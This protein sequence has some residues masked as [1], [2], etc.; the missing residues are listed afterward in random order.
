M[1]RVRL[2]WLAALLQTAPASAD[3]PKRYA[4]LIGVNEYDHPRLPGLRFSVNDATELAAV[5]KPAGYDVTLL[6]D[7]AGQKPTKANI[8]KALKAT[9]EKCRPGDT[10]VV[11]FS[12]HGLQFKGTTDAFFCPSDARP[13]VN[14]K[15]S[16]VSLSKLYADMNDSFAGVKL[17]LVDACRNDPGPDKDEAVGFRGVDADSAPNPPRGV[18]AFFSCSA[19]EQA[20]EHG[21]FRHGVFFHYVLKG[22]KGEAKNARGVVTFNSLTDYV[23]ASVSD[24]VPRLTKGQAKQSPN[25]KADLSGASPVLL[26]LGRSAVPVAPALPKAFTNSLNMQFRL[27]P[28]GTFLMGSPGAASGPEQQH[29]VEITRPFYAGVHEVTQGQYKAVMLANPSQVSRT[30]NPF[31]RDRIGPLDTDK[32]PV[33]YV[34]W[35]QA[36]AFCAT[37]SAR[38]EEQK[39]GRRYRL[40]TEAE[41]EYACRGGAAAA[42]PFAVGTGGTLSSRDANFDGDL[43]YRPE[44]PKGPRLLRST[45]VGSYKPNGFGLYDMHGNAWEWCQDWYDENY[46]ATSPRQ[47]PPGPADGSAKVIRGGG[48]DYNA[49]NCRSARRHSQKPRTAD[50]NDFW[51]MVGFRVVCETAP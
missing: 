6:A 46:Y 10:V 51:Q 34:S 21:T 18:A 4:V 43:T 2:A 50:A 22:L 47:D 36:T 32:F 25:Q 45:T 30:G 24:E 7:T 19:G 31:Y 9:L 12:G 49:D 27:I 8:D 41:W 39:A 3:E 48:W 26:S 16:L 38:P 28:A 14:G 23:A 33:D 1:S 35:D 17:L 37:L 40:P 11:T 5:L 20:V 13:S 44:D 29:E 42:T 15:D